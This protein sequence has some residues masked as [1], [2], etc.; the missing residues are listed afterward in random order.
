MEPLG[1]FA[2]WPA[3]ILNSILTCTVALLCL[4]LP[5]LLQ[6]VR[7]FHFLNSD[8]QSLETQTLVT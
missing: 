4:K 8:A 1:R 6:C 2:T 5:G 7:L 3:V